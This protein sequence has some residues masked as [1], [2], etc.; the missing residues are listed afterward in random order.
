MKVGRE[1]V[2]GMLMAVEIWVKRDHQAEWKEWERR[3]RVIEDAV[4]GVQSVKTEMTVPPI[5]MP[6][7]TKLDRTWAD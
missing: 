4:R 5:A 3:V 6:G 7:R 2:I 1:E